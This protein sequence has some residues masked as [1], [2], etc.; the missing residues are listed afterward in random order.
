MNLLWQQKKIAQQ[1]LQNEISI[2]D[3][4]SKLMS[5]TLYTAGQPD[6]DLIIRPSG[7]FRLSNFLIWQSAY[8]EYIFMDVLWPDFNEY[9]LDKALLEYANRNRR[10]GGI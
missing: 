10:F 7:E 4:D 6:V 2:Q 8:A 5:S 9:H 3:I 1:V